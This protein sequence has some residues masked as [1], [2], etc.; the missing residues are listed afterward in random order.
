MSQPIKPNPPSVKKPPQASSD[1]NKDI[2]QRQNNDQSHKNQTVNIVNLMTK[3]IDNLNGLSNYQIR[4]LVE[5]TKNLGR[6]LVDEKLK[7]NQIRKFLDAVNRLKSILAKDEKREFSTIKSELVFLRPK[8]AY[9]AA[10][11]RKNKHD[12]GPVEPLKEV[13]ESAIKQV[14]TTEDFDRFVQLVE[15]IIAYHKASGGTNQ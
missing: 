7:T 10:R 13:L 5:D 12:L 2:N 4:E 14:D 3:K 15:S 11:Q 9:A 6:K 1:A 8:L